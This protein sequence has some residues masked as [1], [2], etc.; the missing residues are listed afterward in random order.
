MILIKFS[1]TSK[2]YIS[3]LY[4][5]FFNRNNLPFT[6]FTIEGAYPVIKLKAPFKKEQS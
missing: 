4:I 2:K 6:N 3:C 5:W 1:L